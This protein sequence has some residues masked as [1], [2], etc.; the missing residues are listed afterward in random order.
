[1]KFPLQ[2]TKNEF[3]LIWTTTPWTLSSN[4]AVAVN[5]KLDYAKVSMH[6]G[7]IYYVADKNLK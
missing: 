7:S 1:M 2:D 3:L 5:T 4:I 6:D